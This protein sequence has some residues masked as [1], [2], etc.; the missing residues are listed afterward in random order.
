M[1]NFSYLGF[2]KNNISESSNGDTATIR[3][4]VSHN[5]L[6]NLTEQQLEE[7]LSNLK[8]EKEIVLFGFDKMSQTHKEAAIARKAKIELMI[9]S[10][11]KAISE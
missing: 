8:E 4:M 11:E 6:K 5:P 1:N 2:F 7:L 10:V 3:R 9:E